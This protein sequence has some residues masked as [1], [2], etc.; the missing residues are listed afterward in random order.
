SCSRC[1]GG[2]EAPRKEIEKIIDN[3]SVVR[4]LVQNEWLH[5]LQIDTSSQCIYRRSPKG[6]YSLLRHTDQKSYMV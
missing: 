2:I 6:I 1:Q 3:H 5:I 4:N